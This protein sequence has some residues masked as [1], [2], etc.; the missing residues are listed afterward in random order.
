MLK[1]KVESDLNI[2]FIFVRHRQFVKCRVYWGVHVYNVHLLT[3]QDTFYKIPEKTVMFNWSP[4][5]MFNQY[6]PHMVFTA[7]IRIELPIDD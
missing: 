3:G 2:G 6:A 4:C 1:N 5:I 7:I